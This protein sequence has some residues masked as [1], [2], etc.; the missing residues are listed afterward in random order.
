MPILTLTHKRIILVLIFLTLLG[1][2]LVTLAEQL[3]GNVLSTTDMKTLTIT[4]DT[5][6]LVTVHVRPESRIP[7]IGNDAV[8][9][10]VEIR[11]TGSVHPITS[12]VVTANASGV[13]N[14]GAIS[15][16]ILPPGVYDVAVKGRSHLRK[17]YP[18]QQF[19]GPA[20]RGYELIVPQL[21]AGDTHPSADNYV[22][23][24]DISYLTMQ[25]YGADERADLTHDGIVNSLDYTALLR[26]ISVHGEE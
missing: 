15:T 12:L 11:P 23:S 25:L 18:A 16:T 4:G 10:T 8:H 7:P 20:V 19:T 26:N 1:L 2:I 6:H 17:V 3:K 9:L 22:N 24:L 5:P 13:A 14:L 21:A